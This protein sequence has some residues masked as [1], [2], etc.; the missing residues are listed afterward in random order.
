LTTAAPL[1]G[2]TLVLV[3]CVAGTRPPPRRLIAALAGGLVCA[4]GNALCD[5]WSAAHGWWWYPPWPGRGYASPWWY[6]AAGLGIA[7]I[8]LVGWRIHRRYGRRGVALFLL[9]FACYGL[10]RDR[11]VSATVG[12]DLLRF[13]PGILPWIVDWTAWLALTALAL[14]TQYLIAG[15]PI[16]GR[17][18][19]DTVS[20]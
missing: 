10:L 11:V 13:G 2:A 9:L 19:A 7:G 1:L 16:A 8:G 12:R 4:V 18:R 14:A 20:G 3:I 17:P 5:V 15:R 6:A